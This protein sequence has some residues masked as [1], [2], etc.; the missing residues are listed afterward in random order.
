MPSKERADLEIVQYQSEATAP[1]D[2]CPLAWW[3]KAEA[4]CPNLARLAAQYNCIPATATPPA[5]IPL[6]SQ[7][8]FDMKRANLSPEI[9]DQLLFLNSNHNV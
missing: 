4:K 8:S 2:Q 1:L 5:R 9:L 6:E 7:I 3:H